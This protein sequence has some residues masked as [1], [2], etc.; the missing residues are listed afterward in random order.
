M[1]R[2][3]EMGIAKRTCL[4]LLFAASLSSISSRALAADPDE[5]DEQPRPPSN[6][7]ALLVTGGVLTGA[8][9]VAA[10]TSAL[11]CRSL[12]SAKPFLE[13]SPGRRKVSLPAT[14]RFSPPPG[15]WSL[16]EFP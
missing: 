10:L 4:G 2:S 11:Y 14:P 7:V 12:G 13:S 16:W 9:G 1:L 5:D 3:C 6:G 8:G 15:C